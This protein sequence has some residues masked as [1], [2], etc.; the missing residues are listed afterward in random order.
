[1]TQKKAQIAITFNWIYIAIAGA[2]ILMFFV[3]I[4]VKQQASSEKN[5]VINVVTTMKSIFTGAG[6]SEKTK[7]FIST[8]SLKDYTLYFD[9]YGG[10]SEFGIKDQ[11]MRMQELIHPIFSPYEL[12]T[13]KIITWSLPYKLPY[14]II[15]FLF[16]TSDNTIY[17]IAGDGNG[18]VGE[19]INAT[20]DFGNVKMFGKIEDYN[21]IEIGNSYQVRFIDFDSTT[22][23][24]ENCGVPSSLWDLPD[25]KVTAVSF[26]GT[27]FNKVTYFQKEGTQWKKT[28]DED[29]RVVSL[30]GERDAAKYAAIF[31]ADGEMYNCNMKKAFQRL[32]VLNEVYGGSEI[33]NYQP[34]NKLLELIE[35]YEPLK[36]TKPLCIGHL[37][38]F[39]DNL[40]YAL[41]DHQVNT[42]SCMIS[43]ES[44]CLK[45]VE[46][47]VAIK[48]LNEDLNRDC[49]TLY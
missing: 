31:S 49:L 43:Q 47:A 3:G 37:E 14:K 39:D 46:S 19:F 4:V 36:S 17:Y 44:S 34:G 27:L 22:N 42:L 15:D 10:V 11:E 32:E 24:C 41:G 18:F 35:I 1:M 33:S 21:L 28:N 20:E 12:K 29:V 30:G 40:K 16:V 8:S 45:A 2:V 25:D 38:L 26:S 23:I 48:K 13:N 5:L 6:V 9:C 7:N